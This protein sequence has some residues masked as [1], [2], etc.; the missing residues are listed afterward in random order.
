MI[1]HRNKIIENATSDWIYFIDADNIYLKENKG[2]I[3][4][5]AKVL[6]FLKIN[7]VVSPKIIEHDGSISLDNRRMFPLNR[8]FLFKGKVHEEPVLLN[9]DIYFNITANIIVEHDG[10]NP[11]I[12]DMK[13]KNTRNIELT[14]EMLEIEPLNAKWL[15]FYAREIYN[16][17][18]DINLIKDTL[19]KAIDLGRC[20]NS[21][22]T[23][24][25]ILLLCRV[26]FESNDFK[27]LDIYINLLEK[28]YPQCI[29]ADYYRALIIKLDIDYKINKVISL[30]E[31]NYNNI[32]KKYSFINESNDHIKLLILNLFISINDW[33]NA[34]KTYNSIIS[35]NI[36]LVVREQFSLYKDKISN[37][38]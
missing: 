20:T 27:L 26:L 3:K 14:K 8:G 18:G 29:D 2:K 13:R 22:F 16:S 34:I 24:D 9:G 6:D 7:C 25:A 15:Y 37:I 10:Y 38:V 11:E 4:R 36:K 21:R 19:I 28:L 30:L 33:D 35:K 32:N 23:I 1:F 17:N 5:I 12:I 31:H